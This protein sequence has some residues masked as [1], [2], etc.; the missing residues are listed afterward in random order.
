MRHLRSYEHVAHK[1]HF[2]DY[3]GIDIVPGDLYK[4]LV[5]VNNGFLV[6]IKRHLVPGCPFPLEE[7]FELL[8]ESAKKSKS[9]KSNKLEKT[10]PKAA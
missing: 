10:L 4:G 3:C 6:V 1:E 2:C 7:E 5:G 8:K 9:S